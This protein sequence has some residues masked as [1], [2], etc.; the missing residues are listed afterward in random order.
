MAPRAG[1]ATTRSRKTAKAG[2][3]TDAGTTRTGTVKVDGMMTAATAAE[4]KAMV[5]L[6]A[7]EG[8]EEDTLVVAAVVEEA[9]RTLRRPIHPWLVSTG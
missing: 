5:A 6:M 9:K 8:E 2:K 1:T 3:G 7:E 4:D